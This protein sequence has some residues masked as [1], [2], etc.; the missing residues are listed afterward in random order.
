M[1]ANFVPPTAATFASSCPTTNLVGC[2]TAPDNTGGGATAT[3]EECYY[4]VEIDGSA[5][6]L[7][8]GLDPDASA[9]GTPTF[10]SAA[11]TA[12]S[13]RATGLAGNPGTWST[14]P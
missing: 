9:S 1:G 3:T 11:E 8:C 14:T 12:A 5:E 4:D 13:C 2:C 7:T 6:C 10:A